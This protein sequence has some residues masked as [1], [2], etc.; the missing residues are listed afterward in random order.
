MVINT[1]PIC[2]KTFQAK[3]RGTPKTC[4]PECKKALQKQ[5]MAAT[6]KRNRESRNQYHRE[7]IA[8]K[9]AAMTPEEYKAYRDT[10]NARARAN[11]QKRKEGKEE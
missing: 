6:E 10:I 2:G 3:R 4:S 11:Y 8:A 5:T 9:I 7:R 1:C